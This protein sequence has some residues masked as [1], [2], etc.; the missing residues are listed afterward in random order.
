[1][2]DNRG[3]KVWP[4]G[5]PETLLTDAYRCRFSSGV[6]GRTGKQTV[7]LLGLSQGQ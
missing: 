4:E 7:A 6:G 3:V 5:M 2:L 1:M